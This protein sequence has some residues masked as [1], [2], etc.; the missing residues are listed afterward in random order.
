VNIINYP[1]NNFNERPAHRT[2]QYVVLHYTGMPSAA[3]ALARLTDAS[4]NLRVSAHYCLDEDGKIYALVPEAHRAWHAGVSHWRGDDNLNDSSLGIELQNP[5][6][7]FGYRAFAPAQLA[8][9]KNLLAAL[10]QRYALPAAALLAHSDIA[11]ARKQDP[12]ELFPWQ[13]FAA[14]GYG[15]WPTPDAGDF[16]PMALSPLRDTLR[17]IGY[18]IALDGDYDLA[19]R[20]ALLAFQRRYHPQSIS[21]NPELPTL[22]RI[23]ALHRLI[24]ADNSDSEIKATDLA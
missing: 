14:A 20:Q 22:A 9:L 21:G 4:G 8:A 16:S 12:G 15:L 24:N 17:Q 23:R 7:E 11:P 3:A 1:C 10:W 19:L 18:G 2:I 13:K 6:H 5:G